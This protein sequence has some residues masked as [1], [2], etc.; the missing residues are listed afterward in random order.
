ML[1]SCADIQRNPE[2]LEKLSN[3]IN[4]GKCKVLLL[5]KNNPTH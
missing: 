1:H 2:G 5:G 4:N 3:R